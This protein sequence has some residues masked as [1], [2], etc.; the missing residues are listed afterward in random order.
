[1]AG[2]LTPAATAL[3]R[4][5]DVAAERKPSK[6]PVIA[7]FV[8]VSTAEAEPEPASSA[9]VLASAGNGE[10]RALKVSLLCAASEST[11][12]DSDH[13]NRKSSD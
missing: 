13:R 8:P 10:R 11:E 7:S 3:C 2:P 9:R 4:L 6:E 12:P 1:M 5:A